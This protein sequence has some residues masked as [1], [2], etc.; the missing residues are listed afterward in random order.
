M[1]ILDI[2]SVLD[3]EPVKANGSYIWDKD[4][5]KYLDF[6]GGHAVISI[7]HSHPIWAKKLSEQINTLPFYSNAVVKPI[8]REFAQLLGEVSGYND[9]GF[10]AC[11][12][13]AEAVENALKLASFQ[14]GKSKILAFNKAF[15]GRTSGAVSV[16]GYKQNI[17]EFNKNHN[18]VFADINDTEKTV[19]II[20]NNDLA[21]VIIEGIQ[22]VGGIIVPDNEFLQSIETACKLNGIPLILDEVQSGYGRTGKFFAHQYSGIKPDVI[23][24]A[25]GMGNGFPVGGIIISPN[26]EYKMGQLG[27]TFGGNHMAMAAGLAVLEVVKSDE[28]IKNAEQ[29]GSYLIEKLKS[30]PKVKEIRGKGLMIAIEFDM[31]DISELKKNLLF[32][33]KLITGHAGTNTI[34]LLPPLNIT[35]TEADIAFNAI[36]KTIKETSDE[37]N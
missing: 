14:T 3:L 35:K 28:L 24:M 11:N 37:N 25:K 27:S 22:G 23:C 29:V 5:N 30:L 6:Y 10:F 18:I 13:G 9:Y 32:E 20:N 17:S 4:D 1:K 26:M 34:R 36:L 12:S 15:H 7:G 8:E 33:Q 2:Y 16:S 19:E 21:A 31:D